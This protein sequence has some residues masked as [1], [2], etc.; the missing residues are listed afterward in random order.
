MLQIVL[1]IIFLTC[2]S[3][4]VGVSP[5]IIANKKASS[6]PTLDSMQEIRP[7]LAQADLVIFDIDHTIL[8]AKTVYCHSNWFYDRYEEAKAQG[9]SEEKALHALVSPWEQA[10]KD[11]L[12]R[13]V[14]PITPSLIQK[15][16]QSGKKVMALTSRSSNIAEETILQLTSLGVDF[17]ASAPIAYDTNLFMGHGV[18]QKNGVVFTS[19]Y[20]SKGDVLQKYLAIAQFNPTNIVFIDDSM[21]N[22]MSVSKVL[23]AQA[24]VHALLYPLVKRTLPHWDRALA[25][26]EWE[27]HHGK[28]IYEN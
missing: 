21:N 3:C 4:C 15:I 22:L 8:E 25:Q 11:C 20:L 2:F 9:I 28:I 10:Q 14:E 18:L 6:F 27:K 12:V 13:A 19:D 1:S 24:T 26:G 16:Q 7:Y 23:S 5:H 17:S